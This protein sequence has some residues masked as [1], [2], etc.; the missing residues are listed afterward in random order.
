MEVSYHFLREIAGCYLA[1]AANHPFPALTPQQ[2]VAS[3]KRMTEK[4]P[5]LAFPLAQQ[6]RETTAPGESPIPGE[7][8]ERARGGMFSF[9]AVTSSE[10]PGWDGVRDVLKLLGSGKVKPFGG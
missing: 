9:P 4:H 5:G 1:H 3:P 7:M 8:S 6:G 2:K 10:C